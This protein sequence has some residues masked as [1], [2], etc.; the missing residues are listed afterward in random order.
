MCDISAKP[1]GQG[2][3]RIFVCVYRIE[4]SNNKTFKS[5]I[6]FQK[7]V[8]LIHTH[9]YKKFLVEELSPEEIVHIKAADTMSC[10]LSNRDTEAE[11]SHLDIN[12]I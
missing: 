3:D 7:K 5:S 8:P 1:Q 10:D 9:H 11:I 12:S 2:G 6:S 4:K